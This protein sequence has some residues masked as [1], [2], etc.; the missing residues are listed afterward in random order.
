MMTLILSYIFNFL[1]LA[2]IVFKFLV[3]AMKNMMVKKQQD[4]VLTMDETEKNLQD[5]S[6]ELDEYRQKMAE[7]ES[8]ISD[9]KKEAEARA[10]TAAEKITADTTEEIAQL[11]QRVE[12]Q[13]EQEFVNLKNRVRQ[14]FVQEVVSSAQAQL[15]DSLNKTSHANLVEQFAYSLKDFKEYKS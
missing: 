10:Q 4:I 14:E 15:K 12:R 5:M 2:F 11:R 6:A 7:L 8:Q 1:I 13:I 9:I 3:P